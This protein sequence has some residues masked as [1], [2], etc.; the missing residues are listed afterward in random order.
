MKKY[1]ILGL[2]AVI[3]ILS[4]GI[5]LAG[6]PDSTPGK[7]KAVVTLPAKAVEIAPGVF[8][9]GKAIE[10]GRIV[11]GYAFVDYKKGYVKPGT[12]CG[13][14]ICEPGE[15]PN[16]CPVDCD[17]DGED[18]SDCYDFLSKGARWKTIEPYLVNPSNTR[19]LDETFVMNNLAADIVKWETEAGT[20]ILGLGSSTSMT[21]EVDLVDPD[22][23]NELYFGEISDDGVIAMAVVWGIWG[24]PP[25]F[26]E[27]VE[28]DQ[29]YDQVDYDWS[30]SGEEGKMDFENIATHELGHSVGLS[31]LYKG[32]CSEQTMY[33]YADYGETKKR[34]LEA[35]DITGIQKLY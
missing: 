29:I 33:G 35:G 20:D 26:R 17:G 19:G 30:D 28:W 27:I 16:K 22:G 5:A 4:V 32:E 7:S 1:L 12:V 10:G 25:P 2:L 21:L 6:K 13:N 9:L 3:L 8:S 14:G 15:N 24:G 18:G 34:T 31:D 11:E 23:Y